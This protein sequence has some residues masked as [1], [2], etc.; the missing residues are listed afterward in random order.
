MSKQ[1]ITSSPC[2]AL[3]NQSQARE[4]NASSDNDQ[5]SGTLKPHISRFFLPE[6]LN[7]K[8]IQGDKRA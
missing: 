2:M 5:T 8:L 3:A 6:L 1:L 7:V 4:I